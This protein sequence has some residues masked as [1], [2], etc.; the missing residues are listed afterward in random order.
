M[1]SAQ[2][3]PIL[4]R[5]RANSLPF[6]SVAFGLQDVEHHDLKAP[7]RDRVSQPC[8]KREALARGLCGSTSEAGFVSFGWMFG[9]HAPSTQELAFGHTIHGRMIGGKERSV[10]VGV[11]VVGM[12]WID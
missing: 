10:G 12:C 4:L 2:L 9:A 8:N 7:L 1:R 6:A 3:S 11:C 5:S